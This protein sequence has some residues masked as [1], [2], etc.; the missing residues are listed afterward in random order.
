[1][2]LKLDADG[3]PVFQDG[4]PVY[5]ADDGKEIAVDVGNLFKST[6]ARAEQNQ[7]VETENKTLKEQ[8]KA[9]EG[10]TDAQ[11]ALKAL[12][13]VKNLDAKKLVD[14][15]EVEKVKAEAIKAIEEKYA[16]ISQ[17]A[18][19]LEAQL[20]SERVG[21]SFARSKLITDKF[22]IPP[23][24]VQARFGQHFKIEDGKMVA[25]DANGNKLYSPSRPGE[26]ADFDEALGLLVDQYPYKDSILKGTGASGGGASGG[27]SGGG[28]TKTMSRKQFDT[29]SP[30][31]QSTAMRGGTVLTD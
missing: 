18:K 5:V 13:V 17:K 21:G 24:L 26:L 10:I 23:D 14:A 19:D 22:A 4:K 16:P 31:E 1:M 30:V 7:R 12:E 25:S 3:K 11:S 15:G 29:L 6:Q 28:G 27:G 9:F 8:L 20:Y 2:K